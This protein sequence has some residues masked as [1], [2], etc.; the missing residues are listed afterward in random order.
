L[1]ALDR[2]EGHHMVPAEQT[3]TGIGDAVAFLKRSVWLVVAATLVCAVAGTV[4]VL[5]S[6]SG[7]LA[8]TAIM[9]DPQTQRNVLRDAGVID[10]TYDNG[11]V[12][13]VVEVLKSE[14]IAGTV[15][16]ELNLIADPEFQG[17]GTPVAGQRRRIATLFLI[18]GLDA[19]RVGQSY[20]VR[21]SF[22]SK[23]PETAAKVA[24]AVADEYLKYQIQASRDS[25]RLTSQWMEERV[26]ELGLQLNAAVRA[27]QQF[28]AANGIVGT[29][30]GQASLIDKLT[31]LEARADAYRKLYESFVQRLT[32]NQQQES[33]PVASAHVI[34]PANVPLS[35]TYPRVKLVMALAILVGVLAGVG[36]AWVRHLLDHTLRSPKQVREELRLPYLASLPRW[37]SPRWGAPSTNPKEVPDP[38]LSEFAALQGVKVSL[39]LE[40]RTHSLR[41]IGIVSLHSGEG[42]TAF[43]AGLAT[44]FAQSGT[45]TLM[46]DCDFRHRTLSRRLAPNARAGLLDLFLGGDDGAIIVDPKTKARI[47]PLLDREALPNRL[48]IMGSQTMRELLGRLSA[49]YELVLVDLAAMDQGIE[50]RAIGPFIDGCILVVQWGRTTLGELRD[51]IEVLQAGQVTLFG[52]VINQTED[53]VPPMFGITLA[54]LRS[55]DWGSS[56]DRL[57]LRLTSR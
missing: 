39:D 43:C 41:S 34:N 28:R 23:N 49:T 21:V 9:I 8:S 19:R 47:L 18:N 27:V 3:M 42:S 44:L 46:I 1:T 31:E 55:I 4:F 56:L 15:V 45:N 22:V 32:E 10:F 48:D 30:N 13:D 7:Y 26:A 50:A 33:F 35:R 20:I 52:V 36:I 53:G 25:A 57:A 12:E 2:I 29:S 24:N 11:Q 40:R 54:D 14:R 37:H 17:P 38:P 51:A 16:D 6:Q 5:S